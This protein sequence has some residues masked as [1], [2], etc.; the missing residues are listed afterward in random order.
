VFLSLVVN[1]VAPKIFNTLEDTPA[2]WIGTGLENRQALCH[3]MFTDFTDLLEIC[4]V[5]FID[6]YA[7]MV[8]AVFYID[9]LMP[10]VFVCVCD[11]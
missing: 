8:N 11:V 9:T 2:G 6:S 10:A 1:S 7:L 3:F 4:S 5:G